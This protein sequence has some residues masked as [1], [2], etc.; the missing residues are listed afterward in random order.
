MAI[1]SVR[2]SVCLSVCLFAFGWPTILVVILKIFW[3]NLAESC[4]LILP[5]LHQILVDL[6]QGSRSR[7]RK[8]RKI[9]SNV[10]LLISRLLF[11]L[12]TRSWY[13]NV[14]KFMV[15]TA[16]SLNF[17]RNV[18]FSLAS[19]VKDD[20][21]Q[22][23]GIFWLLKIWMQSYSVNRRGNLLKIRICAAIYD[24]NIWLSYEWPWVKVKVMA[25]SWNCQ[26]SMVCSSLTIGFREKVVPVKVVGNYI[27]NT[28]AWSN[29]A[30]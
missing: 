1:S 2:L 24:N 6:D 25:R 23:L 13:Q 30:H 21:P 9:W 7:S 5:R 12:E 15:F 14:G 27:A 22:F 16:V 10:W 18:Q 29:Y 20:Y 28:M 11:E 19:E 26:N 17:I 4:V 8:N 3:W